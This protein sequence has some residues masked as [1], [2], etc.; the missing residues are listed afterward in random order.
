MNHAEFTDEITLAARA[1]KLGEVALMMGLVRSFVV[2][3]FPDSWEF[4]IPD[5]TAQQLT[6]EEAYLHFKQLVD[7][8][9]R[10]ID[11]DLT[12]QQSFEQLNAT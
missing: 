4:Y 5:E 10:K 9:E 1:E 7:R 3:H 6:P 11:R 12:P 2:R 8:S